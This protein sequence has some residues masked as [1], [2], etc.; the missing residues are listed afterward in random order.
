MVR[1]G[2]PR[3]LHNGILRAPYDFSDGLVGHAFLTHLLEIIVT[4]I[5]AITT[6]VFTRPVLLDKP[7]ALSIPL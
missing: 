2:I 7:V 3:T 1:P 4:D 5:L 6:I